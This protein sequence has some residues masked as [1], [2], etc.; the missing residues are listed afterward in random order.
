MKLSKVFF[1]TEDGVELTG[2]L[3]EPEFETSKIVVSIHGMQ[4]NCLKRRD[5]ILAEN[6]TK[7]GISYFCFN[8]RGHDLVNSITKETDGKV[9]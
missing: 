3:H 1:K 9:R 2:L 8:N 7:N 6:F 5:D 4:S